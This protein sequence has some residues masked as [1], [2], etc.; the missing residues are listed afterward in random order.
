MSTKLSLIIS[1]YNA[2]LILVGIIAL[3][4]NANDS[5]FFSLTKVFLITAAALQ[6]QANQAKRI[7]QSFS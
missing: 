7:F 5:T 3:L 6:C 1:D 4:I 2:K